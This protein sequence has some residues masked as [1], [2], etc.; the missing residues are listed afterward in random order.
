LRFQSPDAAMHDPMP[1]GAD[2]TDRTG[3]ELGEHVVDQVRP[4]PAVRA[5]ACPIRHMARRRIDDAGLERA[6]SGI[7]D[8]DLHATRIARGRGL[9]R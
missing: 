7:Q 1:D 2:S 3:I 6:G 9:E 8:E 4:A 5:G